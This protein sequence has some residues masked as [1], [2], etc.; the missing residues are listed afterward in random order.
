M[1]TGWRKKR[2][3]M[4][5]LVK[6]AKFCKLQVRSEKNAQVGYYVWFEVST[7]TFHCHRNRPQT[8]LMPSVVSLSPMNKGHYCA[9]YEFD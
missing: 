4:E 1:G 7:Q 9:R 2:L 5:W 8:N 3:T 6:F